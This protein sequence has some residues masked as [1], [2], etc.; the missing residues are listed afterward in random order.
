MEFEKKTEAEEA[1]KEMNGKDFLGQPM[2]VDWAFVNP[3][4][5]GKGKGNKGGRGGG[6]R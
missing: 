5:S 4:N 6:R 2:A 1:I 3:G